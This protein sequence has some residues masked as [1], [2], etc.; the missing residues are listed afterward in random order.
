[1]PVAN[2]KI[3]III[4]CYNLGRYL[5]ECVDSVFFGD[6]INALEVIIVDDCSTDNSFEIA[7]KLSQKY[8]DI[9]L[10]KND[11]NL[12][13]P[14]T[15]NV[16]IKNSHGSYIICLD[17][18][19]KI[20]SNY[21]RKNYQNIKCNDIDVSYNNSQ[22]FGTEQTLF[23]W[24]EFSIELLRHDNFIHCS[25]MHKKAMWEKLDG[26]DENMIYGVEDYEFWIRAARAGY[27]FKKC[28]DTF[29]WYRKKAEGGMLDS[30]GTIY[31]DKVLEYLR[32]KHEGWFLG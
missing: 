21:I 1:M 17:A 32:K 4:P 27:L 16:G 28:N 12:K 10:I 19:D 9:I 29:L 18:D 31:K 14:A 5:E 24:P 13:L 3:S 30:T 22:C 26:Y 8:K 20:P 2:P 7:Q 11:K 6:M 25:A 23:N 15:R